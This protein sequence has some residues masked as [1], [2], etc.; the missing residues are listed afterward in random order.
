MWKGFG[1]NNCN[2]PSN[3]EIQFNSSL[4]HKVISF[5]ITLYCPLQGPQ[6]PWETNWMKY[7]SVNL[8][9]SN[10]YIWKYKQILSI[11]HNAFSEQTP[12]WTHHQV[13]EAL[14]AP[15]SPHPLAQPTPVTIPLEVTTLLT[16]IMT[17]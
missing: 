10:T 13:N 3:S 9:W 2:I 4:Y 7:F 17:D 12:P 6:I 14:P 5:L 16:F 15:R 11:R 8:Y 1:S